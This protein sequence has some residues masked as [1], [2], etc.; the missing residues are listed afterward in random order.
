MDDRLIY[1]PEDLRPLDEIHA[2]DD[3]PSPAIDAFLNDSDGG[4]D[5]TQTP[6]LASHN[7]P[8][9]IPRSRNTNPRSRSRDRRPRARADAPPR[10]SSSSSQG[11]NPVAPTSRGYVSV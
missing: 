10:H 4:D 11:T 8:D 2:I 7:P 5:E 1:G 6:A 3:E 9:A